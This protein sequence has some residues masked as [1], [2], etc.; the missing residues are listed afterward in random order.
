M[1]EAKIYNQMDDEIDLRELWKT[2]V[3]RNKMIVL[4]TGVVTCG[5]IIYALVKTPIY[6]K[7]AVLKI[8]FFSNGDQTE[9]IDK[10]KRLAQELKVIFIDSK[11]R[12]KNEEVSI[13]KIDP[14]KGFDSFFEVVAQCTNEALCFKEIDAVVHFIQENHQKIIDEKINVIKY[15][16]NN[17]DRKI[18]FTKEQTLAQIDNEI[19]MLKNDTLKGIEEKIHSLKITKLQVLDKKLIMYR[20]DI[21]KY[22]AQL[23]ELIRNLHDIQNKDSS[24]VSLHM[25]EKRD[26]QNRILSTE[27]T[28]LDVQA[29]QES[30]IST[31]LPQLLRD[32]ENII[33]LQLPILQKKRE[34]VALNEL[35]R[36]QEEKE[37]LQKSIN[38]NNYHNTNIVGEI[39]GEDYPIK[40]K[41]TLIVAVAMVTG[42]ILSIFL[43]FFLEFIGKNEHE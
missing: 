40:P 34:V 28:I 4:L 38:P 11:K 5:A 12:M 23:D 10:T 15:K 26:I 32:K 8:G 14:L 36:L 20:K 17:I 31:E 29:E 7:K 18:G 19:D 3:K 1:Q 41:K 2:I 37:I 24:L 30:V 16:I 21:A 35:A 33:H 22:Q 43:A 25:I 13:E 6:E 27:A 42:L 39:L 9:Y